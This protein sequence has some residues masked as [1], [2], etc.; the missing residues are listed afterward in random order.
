MTPG[1]SKFLA[2]IL[3]CLCFLA[4]QSGPELVLR[5]PDQFSP[6]LQ[7]PV[8]EKSVKFA[9]IG[10]SGTGGRNQREVAYRMEEYR[11]VFPFE[12]VLMQ[13]DNLYGRERPI[14]YV[15]KFERPY[16]ALLESGVK[17]Y[18][19]LGNHDSPRQRFYEQFN[20]GGERYYTFKK[21][22]VRF[23]A[24]DTTLMTPEQ[25]EWLEKEL[26]ESKEKWKICFF[27]HPIYSSGLR[28]G[29]H[30][31]M[32][33]VLEPLFVKY[34]VSAGFSGHEHFYERIRPQKGIHYF[35]SGAAGKLRQGNVRRGDL[36]A[37]AFDQDRSFMLI[38]INGDRLHFQAI[39]R[40]GETVDHGVAQRRIEATE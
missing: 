6:P 20:M 26:K 3:L 33:S 11:G 24:L 36:T 22:D 37:A 21:D 23:F 28:H 10:D 14:D 12:F 13:G 19:V 30:L 1:F 38:E 39:S 15:R 40:N 25:L 27:H 16:E 8:E 31:G 5:P 7:L 18:A 34:G 4:C 9:I 2:A 35:I 17:F 32:R 29:G